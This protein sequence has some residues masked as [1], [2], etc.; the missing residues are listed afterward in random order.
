MRRQEIV[1]GLATFLVRRGGDGAA[2][3]VEYQIDLVGGDGGASIDFDPIGTQIYRRLRVAFHGAIQLH[4]PRLN[5][6]CSFGPRADAHLGEG[7][8]KAYF[9]VAA[10]WRVRSGVSPIRRFRSSSSHVA[11][12]KSARAAAHI[13]CL[14]RA[15]SPERFSQTASFFAAGWGLLVGW[16]T[17]PLLLRVDTSVCITAGFVGR[18]R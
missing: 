11:N 3:F 17:D 16:D 2:R 8:G 12:Y 10:G 9:F 14:P 15:G 18:I 6:P 5:H 13:G 7:S 1:D 4:T